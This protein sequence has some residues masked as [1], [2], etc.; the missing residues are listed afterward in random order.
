MC[1]ICKR[2]VC[3]PACP[4]RKSDYEKR[5]AVCGC[6]ICR[7]ERYYRICGGVTVC[8]ACA[9]EVSLYEFATKC[10]EAGVLTVLDTL[11]LTE[12]VA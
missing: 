2:R 7:G 1:P 4:N 3:L 9:E 12:E 6:G 8:E 10:K 5:C 11:D